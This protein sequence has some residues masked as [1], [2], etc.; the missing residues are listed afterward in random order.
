MK[1]DHSKTDKIGILLV[2]LG[3]P[4]SHTTKD[5]RIYLREFLSDRRVIHVPKIVWQIILNIMILPFRSPKT[6][7]LYKSIWQK[8][9]SPLK[10]FMQKLTD[11][12]ILKIPSIN[13]IPLVIDFA[14]N[15]GTPAI[16]KVLVSMQKK[17]IDKLLVIP[18]F[19]QYSATTTASIF[20]NI[21]EVFK[22]WHK[23]PD[24][25]FISCY[26]DNKGYIDKLSQ[27]I[28]HYI[29]N[30][31]INKNFKLLI[32]FHGL[33]KDYLFK[34]D[35]YYCQCY[36]T[37]RLLTSKLNITDDKWLLSFQSRLGYKKWLSPYT[38]ETLINIAKNKGQDVDLYIVCPGFSIDCLET[39]E[40]IAITNKDIFLKSGG[41][42]YTY[43]PCL[44][45][46][47]YHIEILQSI[48][49]DNLVNWKIYNNTD[50]EK[51]V[52]NLLEKSDF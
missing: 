29:K 7:K 34:G 30:K 27:H 15:Y 35:P 47:A 22:Y 44:N 1:Y 43:I 2:N 32:S 40:E 52:K 8:E 18:L 25:R 6:A 46:S 33:P 45:D 10:I 37:A 48:I 13:N 14:M 4:K 41:K 17:S 24:Y 5:I 12:L 50:R 38:N 20:D 28:E 21:A 11:K 42:N 23:I 3:T 51:L 19:P 39:L 36:K 26:H 9:G 16:D 49:E 31:K